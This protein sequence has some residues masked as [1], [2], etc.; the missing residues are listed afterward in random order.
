MKPCLEA[1]CPNVAPKGESRCPD[2]RAAA[3]ANRPRFRDRYGISP[4]LWV[5]IRRRAM[6]RDGGRCVKCGAVAAAIDHIVPVSRG[7]GHDLS[8]LQALCDPCHAEKTKDDRIRER[9]DARQ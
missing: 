1:G 8:N 9:H 4:G 5:K 3:W 2:H 6:R 7:G